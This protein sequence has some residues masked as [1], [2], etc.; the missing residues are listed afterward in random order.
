MQLLFLVVLLLKSLT[1]NSSVCVCVVRANGNSVKTT[2]HTVHFTLYPP[3]HV[4]YKTA[5]PAVPRSQ[6]F[7]FAYVVFVV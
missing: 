5:A 6:V 2:L 1:N 3:Y 4:P 7:G